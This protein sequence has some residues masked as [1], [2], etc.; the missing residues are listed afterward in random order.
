M[1]NAV[2]GGVTIYSGGYD[3]TFFYVAVHTTKNDNR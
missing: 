2:D 1:V 3:D